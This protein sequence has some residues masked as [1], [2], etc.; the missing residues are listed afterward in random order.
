MQFPGD[1]SATAR[2]FDEDVCPPFVLRDGMLEV[3]DRPGIGVDVDLK[4]LDRFTARRSMF[5]RHR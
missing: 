5:N 1:I 4:T 2:Y 3:P